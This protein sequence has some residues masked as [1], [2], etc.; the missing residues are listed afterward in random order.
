MKRNILNEIDEMK[1]LLGYK[2]GVVISE[3]SPP[4][5]AQDDDNNLDPKIVA[6]TTPTSATTP[7]VKTP[8]TTTPPPAAATPP[9]AA[10]PIKIGVKY[11]SIVEL[12]NSLNTKF[13]SGLTADGKYGP[14]T[15]LSIL[16]ALQNLNKVSPPVDG[17]KSQEKI[18][19]VD[20]ANKTAAADSTTQ[21]DDKSNVQSGP[22]N[23]GFA[24]TKFDEL[25]T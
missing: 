9:V 3:Q 12:Q 19:N 21:V 8:D 20:V 14:K 7:E 2:R 1:Y 18:N 16:T 4:V 5:V 13:Q 6:G 24:E 22:A 23:A 17:D 10:T 11:P 25:Y 15:S